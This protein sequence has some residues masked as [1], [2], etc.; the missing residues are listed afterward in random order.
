MDWVKDMD[1]EPTFEVL[2]QLARSEYD[3]D[4]SI[5]LHWMNRQI[6][7]GLS[8]PTSDTSLQTLKGVKEHEG[9]RG[10]LAWHKMTRE[11]AGK[12]GVR[13]ERLA[14][15]VHKPKKMTSYVDGLALPNA[16]DQDCKELAKI[17][18][19]ALSEFTKR[20]TLKGMIPPDL[21]QDLERD[22]SL[23]KWSTAWAFV[24]EQVP[25][26]RTGSR[27]RRRASTT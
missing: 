17:E 23:K 24:L 8:L 3:K 10:T 20:T 5:D 15:K 25:C 21:M 27:Q 13:S 6:Y 18:G 19:Q 12:T 14:D 26:A 7:S 11:V 9:V 2:K 22:S 1:T 16:W 4:A